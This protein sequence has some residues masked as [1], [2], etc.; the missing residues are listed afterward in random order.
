MI[1]HVSIDADDP[2]HVAGV[3]AELWGGVAEPFPPV[4]EGSWI[5]L[6]GDEHNSAVEVYPRGTELVEADGDA[7]AYGV[8]GAA[9]RRSATHIAMG[10]DLD[11]EEVLTI[12]RREGWPA[13]YRKRGGAFGVIELWVEGSRMV[14]V[15]TPE[16]QAEY[17]GA[18][19]IAGWR[20]FLAS[21]G[22]AVPLGL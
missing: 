4:A 22:A 16:M 15:L 13:K 5:A 14:E 9:D 1:F 6:A 3:L 11:M 12:A 7:D 8:T 18:M 19:T 17:T 2:R 21:R 10:T 20:G